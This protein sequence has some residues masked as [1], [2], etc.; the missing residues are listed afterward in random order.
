MKNPANDDLSGP[1]RPDILR[2]AAKPHYLRKFE[3]DFRTYVAEKDLKEGLFLE[4]GYYDMLWD[5]LIVAF[6]TWLYGEEGKRQEVSYPRNWFHAFKERW[7]PEFLKKRWPV[8]YETVVLD[9]QVIYPELRKKLAL[10]DE[11]HIV[12][13]D[14]YTGGDE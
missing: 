3:V 11:G 14:K 9:A 4:V 7:Y 5:H 8:Q 13:I 2:E 12:R 6:R 1:Y 10:P